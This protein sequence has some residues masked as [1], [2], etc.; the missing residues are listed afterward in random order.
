MFEDKTNRLCLPCDDKCSMCIGYASNCTTCQINYVLEGNHC[1]NNCSKGKYLALNS[2][3]CENCDINCL[4]CEQNKTKCTSC[5]QNMFLQ[6]NLCVNNCNEDEFVD[7]STKCQFCDNQCKTCT[8]D[9]LNCLQCKNQS[10]YANEGSCQTSCPPMK[11]SYQPK[12]Q[13]FLCYNTCSKCYGEA[14]DNCFECSTGNYLYKS[15]CWDSCPDYTYKE[16]EVC[17]NCGG[18]CKKCSIFNNCTICNAYYFVNASG[19][20]KKQIEL[21]AKLLEIYNPFSFKIKFESND[22]LDLVDISKNLE[23][24]IYRKLNG[25]KINSNFTKIVENQF[26]YL[27]ISY[28]EFLIDDSFLSISSK[29]SNN[30]SFYF[31]FRNSTFHLMP[32]SALCNNSNFYYDNSSKTCIIK[33][34][35]SFYLKYSDSSN[36]YVLLTSGLSD[37]QAL[38]IS[39]LFK[40]NINNV[41][42]FTYQI[43][44]LNENLFEI[45]FTFEE[46][47]INGPYLTVSFNLST[48]DILLHHMNIQN[49]DSHIKMIDYYIISS[50]EQQISSSTNALSVLADIFNLCNLYINI[51]LNGNSSFLIQGLMLLNLIYILKFLQINFPPNVSSMFK[52]RSVN[53]LFAIPKIEI[54]EKDLLILPQNFRYYDVS[55]YYI[56]NEA[57]N[58]IQLFMI[59]FIAY[60]FLIGWRYAKNQYKLTSSKRYLFATLLLKFLKK[61]CVW[62]IFF[63]TIFSKYQG[64][65]FFTTTSIKFLPLS[66]PKGILN[67][68]MAIINLLFLIFLPIHIYKLLSMMKSI[69]LPQKNKVIPSE[70]QKENEIMASELRNDQNVNISFE[71]INIAKEQNSKKI[72]DLWKIEENMPSFNFGKMKPTFASEQLVKSENNDMCFPLFDGDINSPKNSNKIITSNQK[73]IKIMP[74]QITEEDQI[75]DDWRP[76]ITLKSERDVGNKY[77]EEL[78]RNKEFL[79]TNMGISIQE[80]IE[81]GTIK[82]EEV[83]SLRFF[84]NGHANSPLI[85]VD[86]A[87]NSPQPLTFKKNDKQKLSVFCGKA[88]PRNNPIINEETSLELRLN[89]NKKKENY[90]KQSVNF[91]AAAW[92]ILKKVFEYKSCLTNFIQKFYDPTH[93]NSKRFN[94]RF[95]FLCSE[96]KQDNDFQR[97]FL[98]IDFLR[99][100]F[101]MFF[102]VAFYGQA[103]FQISL[104]TA[105]N[106]FFF[107]FLLVSKPYKNR[108]LML[109]TFWNEILINTILICVLKLAIYDENEQKDSNS[110]QQLGWAI[111]F[112][113]LMLMYSLVSLT[114]FKISKQILLIIRF[115]KRK[116]M[117]IIQNP[118]NESRPNSNGNEKLPIRREKRKETTFTGLWDI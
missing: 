49:K 52:L 91:F 20:C 89:V 38:N 34:S 107:F 7:N 79:E 19:N 102:I 106:L 22:T 97:F 96:F 1:L 99:H 103:V 117:V 118:T 86:V 72:E 77:A 10:L 30:N 18:N 50:S 33:Q 39:H 101:I 31:Y 88:S 108:T 29:E 44:I 57:S 68:S 114:V 4:N 71:L 112:S 21:E 87:A 26:I 92:N 46:D 28:K 76:A 47:I 53:N 85:S 82:N 67:I 23:L 35:L 116:R 8:R 40:L 24:L 12:K 17:L 55:E 11:Y 9:S 58:I 32:F 115:V 90:K 62:S 36:K 74:V 3:I 16:N 93:C 100:F 43:K 105:I 54:D 25:K 73:I 37:E 80:K 63:N 110:R 6:E 104:I 98:L 27:E 13:C 48:E 94:K 69:A 84:F 51:I 41:T 61:I 95:F 15:K 109:L 78:P 2:L 59:L 45:D 5:S 66:K 111:L 65:V 14:E 64:M 83:K 75:K 60:S 42:N 70:N 56:N 81:K 113:N